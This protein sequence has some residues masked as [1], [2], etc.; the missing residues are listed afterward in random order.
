MQAPS[1]CLKNHDDVEICSRDLQGAWV[2]I[3]FYPKDSTP[4]CTTEA[5]DFSEAM[6]NFEDCSAM[7]LGVSPD[8]TKSHRNFIEKKGL[9]ITLLS[10]PDKVVARAFGAFGVKK[11]YGKEYEG[12]I[13][14]TFII[15]PKGQIVH[16]WRNV[17]VKGHASEVL[18]VLKNLRESQ[19]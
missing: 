19:N 6:P 17:K 1:F 15:N 18:S 4:G 9:K 11:L 3:Y 14:S 12:V 16:E 5:C 10:D 13:R 8:S 7:V 2:V